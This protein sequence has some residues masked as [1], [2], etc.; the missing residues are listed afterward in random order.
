M[1]H[2]KSISHYIC[3]GGNMWHYKSIIHYICCGGNMWHY[4]SISHYICCG[5]NM[6]HYKSVS[7]TLHL[8]WGQH[9]ALQ[10]YKPSASHVFALAD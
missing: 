10:V 1:W 9:L 5:G 7:R 4:K 3:C 8:L 2:Y 6:W